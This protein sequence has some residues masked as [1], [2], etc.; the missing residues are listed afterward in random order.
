[1]GCKEKEL[2]IT[3]ITSREVGDVMKRSVEAKEPVTE[4]KQGAVTTLR[5]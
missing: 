5:K 2:I 3:L 4:Q 1:M